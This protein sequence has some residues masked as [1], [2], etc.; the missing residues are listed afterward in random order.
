V[1]TTC[2]S[3]ISSFTTRRR[4]SSAPHTN[5]TVADGDGALRNASS[6]SSASCAASL[7][8]FGTSSFSASR[9]TTT[10]RGA[11][12]GNVL[13]ASSTSSILTSPP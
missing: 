9:T 11:T 10:R 3:L 8:R 7:S 6:R 2:A 13:A 5:T 12:I 4:M 1:F